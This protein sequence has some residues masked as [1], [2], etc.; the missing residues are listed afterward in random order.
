[1]KK[2]TE[3][4]ILRH[5]EYEVVGLTED[6]KKQALETALKI[7]ALLGEERNIVIWS[8]GFE[9]T[10]EMANII[11]NTLSLENEVEIHE[12]LYSDGD[13]DLV[14]LNFISLQTQ[15]SKFV[16]NVLIMVTHLDYVKGL[17][18]FLGFNSY[19][20]HIS[21]AEGFLIYN[22]ECLRFPFKK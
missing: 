6:G 14:N 20:S 22:E 18:C 12:E 9:R 21:F 2:E 1:M 11:K 7:K 19:T 4:L 8:S 17:P 16:G 15:I 3:I 5:P 13:I 10:D